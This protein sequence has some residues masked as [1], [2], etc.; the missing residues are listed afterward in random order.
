MC[1][2]GG[3]GGGGDG[4]AAQARADEEARQARIRQGMY[5]LD[6][7]FKGFNEKFYRN[8]AQQYL[9]YANPQLAQQY[10]SAQDN[11][12]FNLARAGLTASSEAARNAG[13]LQRQYNLA[14][15]DIQGNALNVANDARRSV[16]ANRSE[17]IGQLQATSDPSATANQAIARANTLAAE[18]SFS[19][20][21][22][23]FQNTTALLGNT[24][25]LGYK[26]SPMN[27]SGYGGRSSS[28]SASRVIR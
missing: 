17:L 7:G 25:M 9:N 2:F 3:G 18:Q 8:R 13:E 28:S 6:Q 10:D 1:M 19:P 22:A 23:L 12:S 4:G 26:T 21:G 20:L 15:G 14:R 11:L 24:G 27:T 5:A 16:E